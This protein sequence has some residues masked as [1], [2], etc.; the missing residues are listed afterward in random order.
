ASRHARRTPVGLLRFLVGSTHVRDLS[1]RAKD[2]FVAAIDMFGVVQFRRNEWLHRFPALWPP[3]TAQLHLPTRL[4]YAISRLLVA[5]A[6]VRDLVL[7]AKHLF[8]AA[9]SVGGCSGVP[10]IHNDGI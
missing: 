6:H 10:L 8:V 5:S 9:I 4:D 7:C 3:E 2:L 1:F